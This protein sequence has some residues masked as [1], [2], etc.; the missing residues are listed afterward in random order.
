MQIKLALAA[1]IM[2]PVSLVA[3]SKGPPIMRT[4]GVDGGVTCAACHNT[5][6]AANSDSRGSVT[7]EGLQSYVPGTPQNLRVTVRHPDAARWGFQ[8]TARFVTGN[9]TLKAGSFVPIDAE[10]KV[11]C[12][13]GPNGRRDPLFGERIGSEGPCSAERQ[14]W[15]EHADAPRTPGGSHSFAVQWI[16]P[17]DENGDIVLYV[18]GNAADGNGANTNDRVYTAALRIPLSTN[19][20]CPLTRR[21]QIRNAV[22]AGPHAGPFSWNSMVEIYGSDFQA[23]SRTRIIGAGDLGS[24]RFP[25]SLSCIAVEIAGERAPVTY[26]QQDQINV[27]APTT[28]VTGPVT[29]VVIANPGR[30]NELR[31]DPATVTLAPLAPAFFML[32]T[33]RSIAA[34]FA[35]RRTWWRIPR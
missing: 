11:V 32:G 34:H 16:P 35:G 28:S 1:F 6:G 9:G 19:A 26:V 7:I 10:T 21:P 3:F 5:Y 4:G 25:Q 22:N 33:T 17:P 24:G 23:G 27:Q 13:D 18:A 29:L 8:L 30:P 31:S 12:D 20:S 15:I 2:C 14:E